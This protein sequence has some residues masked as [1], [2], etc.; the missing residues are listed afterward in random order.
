MELFSLQI[1]SPILKI[2]RNRTILCKVK[3]E[4]RVDFNLIQVTVFNS[5][6]V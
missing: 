4:G 1:F 2:L 3:F 6:N 5:L